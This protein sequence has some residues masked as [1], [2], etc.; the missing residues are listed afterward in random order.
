MR[1]YKVCVT[2]NTCNELTGGLAGRL[3]GWLAGDVGLACAPLLAGL[4]HPRPIPY[5]NIGWQGP[6]KAKYCCMVFLQF[7]YH[8]IQCYVQLYDSQ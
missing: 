6:T 4:K 8:F 5:K 2:V 1:I 7:L 3:A